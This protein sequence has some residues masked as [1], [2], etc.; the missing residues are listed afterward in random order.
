MTIYISGLGP[1]LV[2]GTEARGGTGGTS[3]HPTE[4]SSGHRR[5][6]ELDFRFQPH[7]NLYFRV[8]EIGIT[9]HQWNREYLPLESAF[10]FSFQ[11]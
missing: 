4:L 5:N 8:L 9:P 3:S 6:S 11:L 7:D 1:D 10:G 2:R